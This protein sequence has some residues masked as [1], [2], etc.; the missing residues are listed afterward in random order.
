M[1]RYSIMCV[2][3]PGHTKATEEEK[4]ESV[5][6]ER[7]TEHPKP[8]LHSPI[9]ACVCVGACPCFSVPFRGTVVTVG[10]SSWR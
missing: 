10:R 6:F 4:D 9:R 8:E 5:E 3:R 1:W 7:V 2:V